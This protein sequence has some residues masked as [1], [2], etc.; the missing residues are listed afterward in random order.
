MNPIARCLPAGPPVESGSRLRSSS[1]NVRG[2]DYP[3]HR[4]KCN[5]WRVRKRTKHH[6]VDFSTGISSLTE[7]KAEARR[8]IETDSAASARKRSGGATLRELCDDYLAMPR[9]N[10]DYVAKQNVRYFAMIVREAFGKTLDEARVSD[11]QSSLWSEFARIRH[12]GSLQYAVPVKG[13]AGVN[14]AVRSALSIFAK[15]LER[16]YE[17]RGHRLNFAEIRRYKFLKEERQLKQPEPETLPTEIRALRETDPAMWRAIGLARFAGLRPHEV[18]HA[19]RHWLERDATGNTY[20]VIQHRQDEYF[21]A[22]GDDPRR[23]IIL[24]AQ[25]ADDLWAMPDRELLAPHP[26]GRSR[27]RWFDR[28]LNK[29]VRLRIPKRDARLALHRLRGFYADNVLQIN[30][31]AA[32]AYLAGLRAAQQN[33]GHASASTTVD[34]YLSGTQQSTTH[35]HALRRP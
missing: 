24:D 4:E 6:N 17:Q 22:K 25:L 2:I 23:A 11:I 5:N 28:D 13:N 21:L 14:G 35:R 15:P 27:Q 34:N 9:E 1:V 16:E 30:Q 7:A 10:R 3:M 18:H 19:R 12:G 29:W 20:V 31:D 8:I 33:L 32:A 26:E